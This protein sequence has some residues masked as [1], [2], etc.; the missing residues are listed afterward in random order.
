M[1]Q[2]VPPG[3]SMGGGIT[4]MDSLGIIVFFMVV[5]GFLIA[6]LIMANSFSAYG[7]SASLRLGK[8]W[9]RAAAF[10]VGAGVG[11]A[12]VG[13]IAGAGRQ[14]AGRLAART[15]DSNALKEGAA[16]R[17]WFVRNVSRSAIGASEKVAKSSFDA[18]GLTKSKALGRAGGKGGF[19]KWAEDKTKQEKAVNEHIS[20]YTGTRQERKDHKKALGSINKKYKAEKKSAQE[21]KK[22]AQLQGDK[23][24]VKQADELL[25]ELEE[26]RIDKRTKLQD[27]Q[28]KVYSDQGKK[29]SQRNIDRLGTQRPFFITPTVKWKKDAADKIRA[30]AGKSSDQKALEEIKKRLKEDIEKENKGPSETPQQEGN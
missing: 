7:A 18:R 2:F 19:N 3:A 12:S 11:A 13:V 30:S 28:S 25:K 15:R 20:N 5:M 29:R 16:S 26:E 9:G 10:G 23:A 1:D 21:L 4:D 24:G 27:D 17:N 8:K 14:S 6:A 22:E